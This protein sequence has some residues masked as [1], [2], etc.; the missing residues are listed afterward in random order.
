MQRTAF[1]PPRRSFLRRLSLGAGACL[2]TPF[3]RTMEA[4]AQGVVRKRFLLVLQSNGMNFERI[5]PMEFRRQPETGWNAAAWDHATSQTL[6]NRNDW[7]SLPSALAPLARHQK[8]MLIVDGFANRQNG[9]F[10]NH[11][12]GASSVTCMPNLNG[13]EG[14]SAGGLSFDQYLAA[15]PTM[16]GG[17]FRSVDLMASL[18]SANGS[19]LAYGRGTTVPLLRSPKDALV[20]YFGG[21]RSKDDPMAAAVLARKRRIFDLVRGDIRRLSTSLAGGEKVKLDQYLG[22]IETIERRTMSLQETACTMAGPPLLAGLGGTPPTPATPIEDL[23]DAM[24][25]IAAE[26]LA[27]G[28][29]QVASVS[30]ATGSDHYGA[31]SRALAD[32]GQGKSVHALSHGEGNGWNALEKIFTHVATGI[33][34]VAD[35]LSAVKEGD[36]SVFGNSAILWQSNNGGFHHHPG[37][38]RWNGVIVGDAGGKL[39]ADGRYLKVPTSYVK[40]NLFT[41][42][43]MVRSNASDTHA[44]ADMYCSLAHALGAPT[45]TFGKLGEEP[46]KGPVAEM[47]A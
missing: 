23:V 2:L 11:G 17:V 3:V 43:N 29:T 8:K 47:L 38:F 21:I 4:E 41:Q 46:V 18:D 1:Y 12:C 22:S 16:G 32:V 27:C 14:A 39:R 6:V 44:W 24:L 37:Q 40:G 20:R 42:T 9:L 31:W 25:A 15:A 45:D 10:S 19:Q 26:A 7:A 30:I 33:A 36:R 5:T 13:G 34:G 28:L 35:R